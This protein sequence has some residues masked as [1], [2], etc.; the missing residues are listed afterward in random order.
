VHCQSAWWARV[1]KATSFSSAANQFQSDLSFTY[2]FLF[3]GVT[4]A[5]C[6]GVGIVNLTM[7]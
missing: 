2:R 5:A 6:F 3:F 7:C 4:D 1:G